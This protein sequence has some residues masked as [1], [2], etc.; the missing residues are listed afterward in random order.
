MSKSRKK[1]SVG[2][3]PLREYPTYQGIYELHPRNELTVDE[4]Y[5]KVVLITIDWLRERVRKKGGDPEFLDVYPL[6]DGYKNFDTS[7]MEDINTTEGYYVRVINWG[8]KDTWALCLDE[9]NAERLDQWFR[10]MVTLKKQDDF[11]TVACKTTCR[12]MIGEEYA[13]VYRLSFL[14]RVLHADEDVSI[15]EYGVDDKWNMDSRWIRLNG[16][17]KVDC[18]D[19]KATLIGNQSRNFPIMICSDALRN[20]IEDDEAL[21]ENL[22]D[23][24]KVV[25]Y[26]VVLEK[27]ARKL[28]SD[29][30]EEAL[31]EAIESDR[32]CII[33][34]GNCDSPDIREFELLDEDGRILFRKFKDLRLF[35]KH[36]IRHKGVDFSDPGL[37][38]DIRE[39]RLLDRLTEGADPGQVDEMSKIIEN[40]QEELDE[41]TRNGEAL[42]E[43]V[44]EL[45]RKNKKLEE[46]NLKLYRQNSKM[47]KLELKLK[48]NDASFR[49]AD[50]EKAELEE[51]LAQARDGNVKAAER[52]AP[53]LALPFATSNPRGDFL[54]WVRDNYSDA[55]IVHDRAEKEFL[56]D[57]KPRDY[58]QLAR[59]FH[60]LYGLTIC[61]NEN[62][63]DINKAEEIA[64]NYDVLDEGI[65]LT[66]AGDAS[67]HH[68]EEYSIDITEY[69]PEAGSV[70]MNK[71]IS[72]GKGMDGDS[73]RIYTYYDSR[74][75]KTII[76]SMM[77]HL[78][79]AG[80][81]RAK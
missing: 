73:V 77:K 29:P 32:K 7:S 75:G 72:I 71:H 43:E 65:E 25:G 34:S 59:I 41:K 37:F 39:Q 9:I 79:M 62:Q 47:E 60:Y 80:L 21:R 63:G 24:I 8:E 5:A 20:L 15:N 36:Y 31:A 16:K 48:D 81:P 1:R 68:K 46:N 18:A 22:Y 42:V 28:F 33:I 78:P 13:K 14:S 67:K 27:S 50:E 44:E 26:P 30:S 74:I 45:T 49:A 56:A 19:A 76:G 53:L 51:R 61:L 40:L 58:N 38:A 23:A 35:I 66:N 3:T 69:D 12:E 54:A 55:L 6:P 57:N 64:K 10:T 11:V 17:S 52:V 4:L 2:L 70:L